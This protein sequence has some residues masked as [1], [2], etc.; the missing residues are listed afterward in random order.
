MNKLKQWVH[1]VFTEPNNNT[2]CPVRLLA[3]GGFLYALFVHG[4]S[5][6]VMGAAFDLMAFGGAYG[7]MLA[8]LGV[9]LGVKTDS[10]EVA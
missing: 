10:K 3:F 6:F 4:W 8:T 9:A 5:I 1:D 2:I 7:V